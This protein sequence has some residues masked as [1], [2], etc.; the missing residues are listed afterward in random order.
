MKHNFNF[1]QEFLG[2]IGQDFMVPIG[3]NQLLRFI[4]V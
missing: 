1:I 2:L 4:R 3:T